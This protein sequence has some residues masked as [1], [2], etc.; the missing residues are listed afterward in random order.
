MFLDG[1]TAVLQ[2]IKVEVVL[3]MSDRYND[4]PLAR[5]QTGDLSA[6]PTQR[7]EKGDGKGNR[8]LTLRALI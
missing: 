5:V 1:L 3:S 7:L 6:Y 4:V 2:P 8:V